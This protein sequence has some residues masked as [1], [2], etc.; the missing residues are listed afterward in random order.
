MYK[1]FSNYDFKT[2]NEV[3]VF[4]FPDIPSQRRNCLT[5]ETKFK[6]GDSNLITVEEIRVISYFNLL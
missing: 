3:F 4:K 1:L 2:S 5:N 6:P